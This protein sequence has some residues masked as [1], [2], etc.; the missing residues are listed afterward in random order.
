M[1]NKSRRLTFVV[2]I[3]SEQNETWQG[4]IQWVDG[5]ETQCFRSE[6][7]MITLIQSAMNASENETEKL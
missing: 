7:E 4:S 2:Q 3:M 6:L 1:G 5:R